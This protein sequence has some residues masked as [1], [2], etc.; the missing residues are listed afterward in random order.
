MKAQYLWQV[1][2]VSSGTA[3]VAGELFDATGVPRRYSV[4][5]TTAAK[6]FKR[7]VI[8]AGGIWPEGTRSMSILSVTGAPI[9][10]NL[11][12]N[13][14]GGFTGGEAPTSANESIEVESYASNPIY[15]EARS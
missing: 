5:I 14:S 8:D 9:Y 11:G 12:A 6:Q 10:V 4:T 2:M 7:A 13:S 15:I 1:A 3:T